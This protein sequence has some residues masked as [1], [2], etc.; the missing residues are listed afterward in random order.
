MKNIFGYKYNDLENKLIQINEKKYKTRQIYEWLYIH[1]EY[2]FNKM[3]NLSKATINNL[4]ANFTS[5]F[6]KIKKVQTSDNASKYLFELKCGSYIEAVLM[7][8][9]YGNSLCVSSQVGCNIGCSFCASGK[10][11]KVRNLESYEMVQQ[12]LLV[13]KEAGLRV[14]SVVIMGI[15][16][17]FDNYDNVMDFIRIINHPYGLAIGAR[18]ITISTC[19]IIPKIK[20]FIEENIQVNLAVSLHAPNNELRSKLMKIN[21]VYNLSDLINTIR[22]YI[23]K[24]N[25]R[26][27]IE[28]VMLEYINDN[29]KEALEL[30]KLLRGMNVYVNL[31]P[32]NE[33]HDG[34]YKKSSPKRIK[35]FYDYLKK[36]GIN[37]TIRKEFGS[38]IDAACGQLRASEVEE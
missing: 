21:E 9:D 28:Y 26:V 36:A 6:I 12:I 34:E 5:D 8:H 22:Q 11:L 31:I 2:D 4:K 18:H 13:E 35:E 20:D 16:E 30:A 10:L 23:E 7:K 27:T 24:T 25:R 38:N 1:N 29:K 37:V 33:T 14:S 17:P 32:Y 19:G 15:G 3:T